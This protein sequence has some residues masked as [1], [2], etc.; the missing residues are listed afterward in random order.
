MQCFRRFWLFF[1]QKA[2]VFWLLVEKLTILV[3]RRYLAQYSFQM[4]RIG[5][6]QL[7]VCLQI[8]F[9][10]A[11]C[12]VTCACVVI[13]TQTRRLY[14]HDGQ[15]ESADW[16]YSNV[17]SLLPIH[18]RMVRRS[19]TKPV[20]IMGGSPLGPFRSFKRPGSDVIADIW[21]CRLYL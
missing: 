20:S 19:R 1:S 14:L 18:P 9:H 2:T 4:L 11:S 17:D 7:S 3:M 8:S 6:I 16:Q 13:V 5:W 10:C 15:I 21:D 12:A